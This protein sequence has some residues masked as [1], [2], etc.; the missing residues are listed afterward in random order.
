MITMSENERKP[1]REDELLV[2]SS[3][4]YLYW[5]RVEEMRENAKRQDG[6]SRMLLIRLLK[7]Y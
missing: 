3:S 7:V 2:P 4:V 5:H 6:D 1:I